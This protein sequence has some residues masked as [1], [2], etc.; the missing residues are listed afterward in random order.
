[1]RMLRFSGLFIALSLLSAVALAAP[2]FPKLTG[3]VVDNADMLSAQLEEQ[4]KSQLA[5]HES[6]TTDQVVVVTLN[7]LQGYSIDDYGYQL[8]RHWKIGQKDK[9]N[10]VLLIV[11]KK[12]RKV[13]I[14]VG[15]GLEGKMTDAR[16][17]EII[18]L[19]IL[20]AF[21]R[22]EFEQGIVRGVES[23]LKVLGGTYEDVGFGPITD[24]VGDFIFDSDLIN[25]FIIMIVLLAVVGQL[26]LGIFLAKKYVAGVLGL[27]AFVIGWLIIGSVIA[28]LVIGVLVTI[29]SLGAGSRGGGGYGGGGYSGG[30]FSGGGGGF[31]G[32][33]GS[34]GGGGA[35]GGW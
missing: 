25:T 34:F 7:D 2:E 11:A 9:N 16:A 10:G 28:G 15:Y 3:R 29:F 4:I 21:K 26:L 6:K 17:S 32:G 22:G 19:R 20:P 8:G 30:G 27:I 31:S 12:E 14:E 5:A 33:G 23:I 1:M 18:F 35:S 24:A 13:R